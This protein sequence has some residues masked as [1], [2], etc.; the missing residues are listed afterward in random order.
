[1]S[2]VKCFQ[3][4]VIIDTDAMP[5]V[6]Y[7]RLPNPDKYEDKKLDC[8]ICDDCN[9]DNYNQLIKLKSGQ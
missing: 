8:P 6:Y 7:Q 5:E 1:M 2:L 9:E 3:C 4:S